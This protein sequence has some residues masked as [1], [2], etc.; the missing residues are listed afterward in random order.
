MKLRFVKVGPDLYQLRND[1]G[2]VLSVRRR[3]IWSGHSIWYLEQPGVPGQH[4]ACGTFAEM[5]KA[6]LSYDPATLTAEVPEHSS[7][8]PND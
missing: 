6:A 4:S 1:S 2:V 3:W 8:G 7:A 5:R